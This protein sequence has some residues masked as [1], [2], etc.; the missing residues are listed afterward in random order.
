MSDDPTPGP[1]EVADDLVSVHSPS[2]CVIVS[3]YWGQLPT[4]DDHLKIDD[5]GQLEA[6]AQLISAA[7]DL[8]DAAEMALRYLVANKTHQRAIYDELEASLMRAIAKAT[9]QEPH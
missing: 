4:D 5:A 8:L 9:G 2:E 7:P 1:W 3:T 6:N